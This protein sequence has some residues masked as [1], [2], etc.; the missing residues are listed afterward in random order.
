MAMTM[1][2]HIV[3][4]EEEIF[5]GTVEMVVARAAEGEIGVVARHAPFLSKLAPGEVRVTVEGGNQ[6]FFYASGGVI[7]VQPHVVT[8]LADTALRAKDIDE[9][10]ALEAKQRAEE[11]LRDRT[12]S[13]EYAEAQAELAEAVAQLRAL[14]RF[15]R[16]GSRA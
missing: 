1:H 3:S 15:R 11:S 6:E 9:A 13:V 5:S 14:E 16:R 4:A 10:S 12:A 8:I 7:E 2:L